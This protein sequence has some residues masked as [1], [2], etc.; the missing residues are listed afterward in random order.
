MV[1]A[2]RRMMVSASLS[3]CFGFSIG[4]FSAVRDILLCPGAAKRSQARGKLGIVIG[5][6]ISALIRVAPREFVVG[7]CTP[8]CSL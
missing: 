1:E 6:V 2:M 7:L 5:L 3:S 8:P 4:A